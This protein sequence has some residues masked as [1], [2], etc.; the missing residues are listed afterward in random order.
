MLD[1]SGIGSVRIP[2]AIMNKFVLAAALVGLIAAS[3][4]RADVAP[5]KGSKRV[6]LDHKIT[7]DKE[8]PDYRFYTVV[9]GG[10]KTGG[11]KGNAAAAANAKG[12][13]EVKFDPKTPIEIKAEGRGAGIGRQGSLVAVPK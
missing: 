5:P 1:S 7:T 9:G 11:F 2:E 3:S 6:A 12:V 8:Y 13:T 4:V 10:G